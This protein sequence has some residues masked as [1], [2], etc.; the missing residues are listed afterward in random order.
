MLDLSQTTQLIDAI[1]LPLLGCV[2][3]FFAKFRH[4]ESAR[5][6]ERQFY[7]VL[8]VMTLV[9]IRTVIECHDIWLIHT[10]ALGTLVIAAMMIPGQES[11]EMHEGPEMAS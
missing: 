11:P 10:A 5:W 6:A 1:I 7:G 8:V 9:T 3:L 2:T 4:G